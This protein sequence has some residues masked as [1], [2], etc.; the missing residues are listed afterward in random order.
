MSFVLEDVWPGSL[1]RFG[2]SFKG[3]L[4]EKAQKK[5]LPTVQRKIVVFF[6]LGKSMDRFLRDINML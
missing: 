5:I 6:C 2:A 1:A 4:L 3:L